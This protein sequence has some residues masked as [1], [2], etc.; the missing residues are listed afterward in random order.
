MLSNEEYEILISSWKNQYGTEFVSKKTGNSYIGVPKSQN[1]RRE[2]L[3]VLVST[4]IQ[5]H[6]YTESDFGQSTKNKIIEACVFPDYKKKDALRAW[7]AAVNADLMHVLGNIFKKEFVKINIKQE[8]RPRVEVEEKAH[9][10]YNETTYDTYTDD[11]DEVVE[12]KKPLDRSIFS[13]IPAS[14][15]VVDEEFMKLIASVDG[16]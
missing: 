9:S 15:D 8:N 2:M 3:H 10:A 12:L 6:G 4:L 5:I 16:Q 11:D 1:E 14:Q 13:N 7:R